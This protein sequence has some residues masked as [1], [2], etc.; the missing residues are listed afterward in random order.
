MSNK[1]PV[2]VRQLITAQVVGTSK[3]ITSSGTTGAT[4]YYSEDDIRIGKATT[5]GSRAE[6]VLKLAKSDTVT[7]IKESSSERKTS[8]DGN[9]YY[10]VTENIADFL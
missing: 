10:K 4:L 5:F 6:A 9:I 2:V 8:N 3:F 1:A 7:F